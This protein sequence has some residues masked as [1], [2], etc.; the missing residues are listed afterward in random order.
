MA[1]SWLING[2]HELRTKWDDPPSGSK[3]TSCTSGE[4]TPLILG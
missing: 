4:I 1:F 3:V 2:G